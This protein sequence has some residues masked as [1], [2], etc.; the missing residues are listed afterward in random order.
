MVDLKRRD[1]SLHSVAHLSESLR[2]AI[3][4]YW[5]DPDTNVEIRQNKRLI[6]DPDKIL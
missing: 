2:K 3:K 5:D 1:A 6:N 4:L